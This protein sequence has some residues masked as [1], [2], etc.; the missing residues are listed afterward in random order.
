[1]EK[2]DKLVAHLEQLNADENGILRGGFVSVDLTPIES[3][4][5]D[6]K[7]TNYFQCGCNNYQCHCNDKLKPKL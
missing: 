3:E 5:T 1:M 7:D 4:E 6:S 2:L